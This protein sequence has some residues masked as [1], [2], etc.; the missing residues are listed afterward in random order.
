M[1]QHSL[2]LFI[3]FAESKSWSILIDPA[4]LAID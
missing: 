4:F 2:G 3:H 1:I